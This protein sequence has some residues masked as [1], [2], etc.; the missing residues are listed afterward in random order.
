MLSRLRTRSGSGL[1]HQGVRFCA[2]AAGSGRAGEAKA[3]TNEEIQSGKESEEKSGPGEEVKA[4]VEGS[5]STPTADQNVEKVAEDSKATPEKQARGSGTVVEKKAFPIPK[6]GEEFFLAITSN[7]RNSKT[8]NAKEL[9][10]NMIVQGI[11]PSRKLY[12]AMLEGFSR[13]NEPHEA[14]WLAREMNDRGF[15]LAPNDY[16]AFF[17][18][19]AKLR[20]PQLALMLFNESK[21]S[22]NRLDFRGMKSLLL[23]L[24]H[25]PICAQEGTR[26]LKKEIFK[27]RADLK[28][29]DMTTAG[30]LCAEACGDVGF[31]K[32]LYEQEKDPQIGKGYL[33]IVCSVGSE[34]DFKEMMTE[35]AKDGERDAADMYSIA[36]FYSRFGDAAKVRETLEKSKDMKPR[37][38]PSI[39]MEKSILRNLMRIPEGKDHVVQCL[40]SMDLKNTYSSNSHQ[41][42]EMLELIISY[43]IDYEDFENARKIARLA[44]KGGS[45]RHPSLERMLSTKWVFFCKKMGQ[46]QEGAAFQNL[47]L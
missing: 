22:D 18:I 39:A 46:P 19:Y 29:K 20:K 30:M 31:A 45:S 24:H 15:T 38:V 13:R 2:D 32:M 11:P 44:L 25:D 34:E 12:S 41:G 6:T 8:H 28:S 21:A 42:A 35:L 4:A 1:I 5:K 9:Y 17:Y 14:Q 33:R 43:L 40:E 3:K 47:S 23:A 10:L 36:L 7:A 16:A 27:G 37:H 26:I